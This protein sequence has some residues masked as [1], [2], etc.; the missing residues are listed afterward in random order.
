[1]VAEVDARPEKRQTGLLGWEAGYAPLRMED[2]SKNPK[3]RP[4]AGMKKTRKRGRP[5][6]IV[7][8][9]KCAHLRL[10]LR[11]FRHGAR[12][13]TIWEAHRVLVAAQNRKQLSV[14]ASILP[15]LASNPPCPETAHHTHDSG[16][17]HHGEIATGHANT[18]GAHPGAA[19]RIVSASAETVVNVVTEETVTVVTVIA[20]AAMAQTGVA[21]TPTARAGGMKGT[22]QE[23]ARRSVMETGSGLTRTPVAR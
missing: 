3:R 14:S 10:W 12:V 19:R 7:V 11:G 2:G 20:T 18:T 23:T 5:V 8:R 6:V 16:P 15:I 4:D 13:P 9:L 17:A 1:M 21:M 22:R